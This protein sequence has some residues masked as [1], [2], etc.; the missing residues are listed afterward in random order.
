MGE[1]GGGVASSGFGTVASTTI[2]LVLTGLVLI[3]PEASVFTAAVDAC[4]AAVNGPVVSGKVA[5]A[6]AV[7]VEV[8]IG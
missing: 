6:A 1:S 7:M 3:R 8:G 4:G 2:V 5:I